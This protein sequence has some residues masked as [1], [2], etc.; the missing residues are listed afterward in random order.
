MR[1]WKPDRDLSL[2][3]K[4]V[5]LHEELHE[6]RSK[7]EVNGC[8][9]L[10]NPR[11]KL[12]P[13]AERHMGRTISGRVLEIG[14][15]TGY[16][17]AWIAQNRRVE[18]VYALEVTRAAVEKLIPK[19]LDAI[20][21]EDGKVLPTLGSF[22]CIPH[23]DF[24]DFVVSFGAIHH[25]ADLLS[26]MA[27]CYESLKRGGLMICQEPVSSDSVSNSDFIEDYDQYESFHGIEEIQ[28]KERHD[29]FFRG[30][31]YKVAA[32]FSGFDI[33]LFENCEKQIT[34]PHSIKNTLA[35]PI[36]ALLRRSRVPKKVQPHLFIVKKP[37][38]NP[39]YIPHLWGALMGKASHKVFR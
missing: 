5:A 21:V 2:T 26:T 36:R 16:A 23:K 35:D 38:R 32:Y 24:F 11:L 29:H 1:N 18:R 9:L 14:C 30:C 20:G 15:G 31:E 22:N 34:R 10:Q 12:I 33:V 6:Q 39:G 19:T 27:A 8:Q 17:S 7:I 28:K 13:I 3:N 4:E 25:S 37:E